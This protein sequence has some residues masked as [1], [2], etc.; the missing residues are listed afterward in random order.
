SEI[1]VVGARSALARAIGGD[2][3]ARGLTVGADLP[4]PTPPPSDEGALVRAALARRPEI[5]AARRRATAAELA[6]RAT[7][8]RYVPTPELGVGYTRFVDVPEA[9]NESGGAALVALAVPLPIF[10]HGQGTIRRYE[11]QGRAA[12]T[13]ARDVSFTVRREVEQATGKLRASV[14]SYVEHREHA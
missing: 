8:R 11:E 6:T 3:S 12:L 7:R 14:A 10:D 9:G 13:R 5:T 2:T 4:D 1:D